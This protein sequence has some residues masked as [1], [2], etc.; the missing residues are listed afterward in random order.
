MTSEG[1]SQGHDLPC[2][3]RSVWALG[4]CPT[5]QPPKQQSLRR[6]SEPLYWQCRK[7]TSLP[8]LWNGP[9][10]PLAVWAS[11]SITAVRQFHWQS[12]PMDDPAVL[13]LWQ[14]RE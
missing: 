11:T 10:P 13:A 14:P 7:L 12:R 5:G 6:P 1:P 9:T 3:G 8:S 2:L 4:M